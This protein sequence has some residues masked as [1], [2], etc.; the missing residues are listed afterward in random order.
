MGIVAGVASSTQVRSSTV[1]VEPERTDLQ[2][3]PKRAFE[4]ADQASESTDVVNR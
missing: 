4:Q 1:A 3:R 2:D